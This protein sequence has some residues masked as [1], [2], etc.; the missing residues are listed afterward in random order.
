MF[1][2]LFFYYKALTSVNSFRSHKKKKTTEKLLSQI[3]IPNE[4][5]CTN[6]AIF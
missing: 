3:I 6:Y 2:P 5:K 1:F 4:H